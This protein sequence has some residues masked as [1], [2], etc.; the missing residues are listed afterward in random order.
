[1]IELKLDHTCN[2][3]FEWQRHTQDENEV[4]HSRVLLDFLD[5]RAE[6]SESTTSEGVKRSAAG[7]IQRSNMQTRAVYLADTGSSC[8]VCS[9]AKHPLYMCRQFKAMSLEQRNATIRENGLCLNYLRPGDFR[10]RC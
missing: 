6:A 4:S 9:L 8:V 5:V 7:T 3:I 1:M 2:T 10:R